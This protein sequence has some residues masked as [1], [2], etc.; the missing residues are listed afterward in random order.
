MVIKDLIFKNRSYRR[1][2]QNERISVDTLKE[3][4]SLA[5]QSPSAA[6]LQPLKYVLISEAKKCDMVFQTLAWAG[7]ITNWDGP[8]EG[9][10]PAGYIIILGDSEIKKNIDCDHGIAAQS[11][12]LGAVEK[13]LGGCIIASIKREKLGKILNIDNR[14]QILLIIAL[15][16]PKEEVVI[17]DMDND[18][19]IEYWRDT[20]QVHHVPKRSVDELIIKTNPELEAI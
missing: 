3:L 4:I 19:K 8:E 11:I 7:Y 5:R 6:N 16:K 14:Y 9:E 1:F 2:F 10:R 20:N 13:N 15:G 18:G 17:E 12:L